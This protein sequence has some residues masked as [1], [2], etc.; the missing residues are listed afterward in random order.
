MITWLSII[1][2]LIKDGLL[3]E[4]RHP[5]FFSR[6]RPAQPCRSQK[7]VRT[8]IV[9]R[10]VPCHWLASQHGKRHIEFAYRPELG[11]SGTAPG[12][13]RGKRSIYLDHGR[14]PFGQRINRPHRQ[15]ARK[16]VEHAHAG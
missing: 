13:D 8:V 1:R 11:C 6:G 9:D 5:I 16:P 14:A 4:F 10:A 3:K 12:G 7:G 2:D 15:T